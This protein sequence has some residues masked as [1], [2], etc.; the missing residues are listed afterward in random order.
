MKSQ[1][2]IIKEWIEDIT[3]QVEYYQQKYNHIHP[4]HV[5]QMYLCFI[6]DLKSGDDVDEFGHPLF[7][8]FDSYITRQTGLLQSIQSTNPF[9][10]K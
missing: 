5:L 3:E 1:R 6:N 9:K 2:Q 8:D 7:T 4:T 10:T